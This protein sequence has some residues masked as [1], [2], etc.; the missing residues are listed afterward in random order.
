M[1]KFGDMVKIIDTGLKS[2]GKIGVVVGETNGC[3]KVYLKEKVGNPKT[4][5]AVITLSENKIT[6]YK[7][8]I[9]ELTELY[10]EYNQKVKQIREIKEKIEKLEIQEIIN[11]MG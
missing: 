1:F 8:D 6:H 9:D 11:F 10:K 3:I 4:P 2:Y 5:I 7:E